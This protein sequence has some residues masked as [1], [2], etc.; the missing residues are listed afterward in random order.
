M[1]YLRI[2]IFACVI[3]NFSCRQ[4]TVCE[5]E[6]LSDYYLNYNVISSPKV[7]IYQSDSTQNLPNNYWYF[8]THKNND[9]QSLIAVNFD[10]RKYPLQ[11]GLETLLPSGVIGKKLYFTTLDSTDLSLQFEPARIVQNNLFPFC[12]R[13]KGG[14]YLYHIQWLDPKY[15]EYDYALYRN[16]RY[17]AD[18]TIVHRNKPIN[19]KVFTTKDLI[20][21]HQEDQGYSQPEMSGTEFYQKNIGL[22]SYNKKISETQT[23]NYSL[24]TIIDAVTFFNQNSINFVEWEK[25]IDSLLAE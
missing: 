19:V 2:L 21:I 1:C 20:E 13:M 18:S 12:A 17:F 22:V 23:I 9:E 10:D 14:V 6:N 11:I 25:Y 15:P 3:I 16:R 7:Y 5:H 24:D 8:A 4:N